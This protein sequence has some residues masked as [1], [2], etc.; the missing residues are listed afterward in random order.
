MNNLSS[1]YRMEREE[2]LE[3]LKKYGI[4]KNARASNLEFEQWE[5]LY[6]SLVKE[7]K[8]S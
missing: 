5:D 6:G 8:A 1:I 3:M 4:D 2:I 7:K